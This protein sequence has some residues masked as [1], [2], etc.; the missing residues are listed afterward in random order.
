MLS[1]QRSY[2]LGSG[3]LKLILKLIQEVR[4]PDLLFSLSQF[5]LAT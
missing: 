2:I 3:I 5:L 4:H 1:V